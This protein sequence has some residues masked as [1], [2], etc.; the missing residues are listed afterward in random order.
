MNN[1]INDLVDLFLEV[2]EGKEKSKSQVIE[3]LCDATGLKFN[4]S[5]IRRW[6]KERK[7]PEPVLHHMQEH[8]IGHALSLAGIDANERQAEYLL[9]LLQPSVTP[10]PNKLK[11]T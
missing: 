8:V 11:E 2:V 1:D 9:R 3:D 7:L 4:K 6:L 10:H 5:Y